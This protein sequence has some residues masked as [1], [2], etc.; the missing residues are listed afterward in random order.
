MAGRD[1]IC[2]FVPLDL[3][4]VEL[5]PTMALDNDGLCDGLVPR[6]DGFSFVDAAPLGVMLHAFD[7]DG[8]EL[9]RASIQGLT[10]RL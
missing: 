7:A 3:D 10:S 1:R 4:G 9:T 2:R 5:G 6:D 8:R